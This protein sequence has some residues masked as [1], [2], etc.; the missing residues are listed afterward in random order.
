MSCI[1]DHGQQCSCLHPRQHPDSFC[2]SI[3][4]Q[5]CTTA[6]VLAGT[7]ICRKGV[8]EDAVQV[9]ARMVEADCSVKGALAA[10]MGAED[11]GA[12]L[13]R[14]TVAVEE[15]GAVAMTV[16]NVDFQVEDAT[17][18]EEGMEKVLVLVVVE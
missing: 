14:E 2:K 11:L 6:E 5:Q 8:T 13:E 1:A 7:D 18:E 10:G 17:V 12:A 15:G 9:R 3:E 4:L 16:K